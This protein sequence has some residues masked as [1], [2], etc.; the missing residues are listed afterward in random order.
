MRNLVLSSILFF[1][2]LQ[3]CAQN[4]VVS[5]T[6]SPNSCDGTALFLD[7]NIYENWYW[8]SLPDSSFFQQGGTFIDDL[9]PGEYGIEMFWFNRLFFTSSSN[10]CYSTTY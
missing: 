8:Y 1:L 4:V 7:T 5:N 2:S 3:I 9:C 6:T 10:Q